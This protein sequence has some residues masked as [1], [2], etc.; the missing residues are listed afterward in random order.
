MARMRKLLD[1]YKKGTRSERR[2]LA[3]IKDN[4]KKSAEKAEKKKAAARQEKARKREEK[5][6]KFIRDILHDARL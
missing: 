3:Y 2:F 1:A 5:R 4:Q 6:R